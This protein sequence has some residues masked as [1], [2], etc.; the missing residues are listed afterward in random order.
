MVK[1]MV[2][3]VPPHSCVML[4]IGLKKL[5]WVL[6]IV[7]IKNIN[8]LG[9]F[10][11]CECMIVCVCYMYVYECICIYACMC[12]CVYVYVHVYVCDIYILI[13]NVCYFMHA[14][15][16]TFHNT[17]S[18]LSNKTLSKQLKNTHKQSTVWRTCL[19]VCMYVY[20]WLSVYAYL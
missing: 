6:L 16:I 8:R 3:T 1:L 12:V 17:I 5:Y 18:S 7:R 15:S 10:H 2:V 14:Q 4:W 20:V 19:F 11:R 9:S 13:F